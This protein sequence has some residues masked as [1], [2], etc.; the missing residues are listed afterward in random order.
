VGELLA[1]DAAR[2][3]AYSAADFQLVQQLLLQ[4]A[5]I[6]LAPSKDAM[7]YSRLVRRV[8]ALSLPSISAY[9]HYVQQTQAEQQQFINALTTNLT[10]FFRESHHFSVLA[11]FL[12]EHPGPRRIWCAASSTGEEPY[13]IAMTVADV[14]GRFDTPVEIIA[15]DI[16]SQVLAAA[17]QGVYRVERIQ[18]LT[19]R[20]RQQFFLRGKG[21]NQGL[22][23]VRTELQ[24]M[25]EFRQIN[26]LAA[27]WGIKAPVD[28]IF[29]RN[30]MIYFDKNV[31]EKVL[32]QMV[33]LLPAHGLYIAG[34]SE[35]FAHCRHLVQPIGKTVYR[36]A[37]SGS[38][39]RH[40]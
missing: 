6:K 40:D 30:V 10:S 23:K 28:V 22:V 21:Q 14:F 2:E 19:D 1:N 29:C 16:D 36:R 26:L 11:T 7:V 27:D 5:G 35:N 25:I 4:W 12:S 37:V 39:V 13:S 3:F 33:Q 31:Q 17:A 9:L 8:R 18:N 32:G 15:S 38:G 24:R 34:H 20:Q